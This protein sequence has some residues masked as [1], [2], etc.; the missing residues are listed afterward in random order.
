MQENPT[1]ALTK[2]D[3]I[4]Q[5][6]NDLSDSSII[7]TLVLMEIF[8]Q[9]CKRSKQ[10]KR[11]KKSNPASWKVNIAKKR[12]AEGSIYLIKNKVRPAKIP[13][14]IDCTKCKY[15]CTNKINE[16]ARRFICRKYWNF[17]YVEQKNFLLANVE[18]KNTK[19]LLVERKRSTKRSYTT[20]CFFRIEDTRINVCQKFFCKTLCI[21]QSVVHNA[22]KNRDLVGHFKQDQDP[23]GR[24]EPVN[25][26]LPEKV[27]EVRNHIRSF[28]SMESHYIRKDSKRQY[29]DCKLSIGKMYYLYV[30]ECKKSLSKPVS[31]ITYRRIFGS[32]FNLGF[33]R[34]KKDQCLICMRYARGDLKNKPDLELNYQEHVQRKEASM[35]E[36]AKDKERANDEKE[37]VSAS[38][39]LQ[40]ILQIPSGDVGLLYYTRKLTVYNLTVYESALPNNAY[41]FTWS[42]IN[43]KK[44][45]N[46]IGTI[47]FYYLSECLPHYVTEVSMFSDTCGGQNRNKNVA[48][49]LL[50]AVQ[51]IENINIIEQKFLESGHSYMEADSMHSSIETAQKNTAIYSMS[52]WINVF[53]RARSKTIYK[54][55]NKKITKNP[56]KVKEF[57]H[58]EFKDLKHLSEEILKNTTKD[59]DGNQV[60]WLKV[61]RLRYIKGE[62]KIFYN[63]DMS[64]NF[65]SIDVTKKFGQKENADNSEIQIEHG[66][67]TRNKRRKNLDISSPPP[68]PTTA[69]YFPDELLALYQNPICISA[70][71][72]KDLI[73]LCE[74]GV[75]PEE[76]HA[77]FQGLNT[78]VGCKD[79][80]PDCTL[81]DEDEGPSSEEN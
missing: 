1:V 5:L 25:K 57:K 23:R 42:E 16:E 6:D 14:P 17:D 70:A 58:F 18:V 65:C 9:A 29:L 2:D 71:K 20:Q 34:P 26:T 3:N 76:F 77:W 13:K 81:S 53:K 59:T 33:F 75:I 4:I 38:F 21:A 35:A 36:K 54:K 46:E 19:T 55:D 49:I 24:H 22:V 72:K 12:R 52:D 48:A 61:K 73:Q 50:W 64:T 41:C 47:L 45:S 39:D 7:A 28:P 62:S 63:Y 15:E 37:F 80:L 11:W 44:G 78:G 31:E 27:E 66:Y 68:E 30:E 51:K 43:G 8:D 79:M 67:G 32:D 40:S 10:I 69:K 74:K 60:K 56:Y